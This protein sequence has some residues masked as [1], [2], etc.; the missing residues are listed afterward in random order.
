[1]PSMTP[2]PDLSRLVAQFAR[3]RVLVTQLDGDVN[4][5]PVDPSFVE[6]IQRRLRDE[7]MFAERMRE[8]VKDFSALL[9]RTVGTS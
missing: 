8:T 4:R 1:M 9:A 2:Q 6:E 5:Q 7:P 3:A